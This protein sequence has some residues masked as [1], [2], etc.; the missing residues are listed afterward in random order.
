MSD[1]IFL[2]LSRPHNPQLSYLLTCLKF[3]KGVIQAFRQNDEVELESFAR[4]LSLFLNAFVKLLVVQR[5]LCFAAQKIMA[6]VIFYFNSI[7]GKAGIKFVNQI[8]T[9]QYLLCLAEKWPKSQMEIFEKQFLKN[10]Q[11]AILLVYSLYNN[12]YQDVIY[13]GLAI[14]EL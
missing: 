14:F 3:D 7:F 5:V 8:F 12:E 11:R 2:L 13:V 1:G 9:T 10:R 4:L 6:Q